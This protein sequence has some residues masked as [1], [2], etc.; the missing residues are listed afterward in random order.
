M[1]LNL[2]FFSLSISFTISFLMGCV[3]EKYSLFTDMYLS[4]SA[5]QKSLM[6]PFLANATLLP[7]RVHFTPSPPSL[8][9]F[10]APNYT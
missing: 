1:V 9:D 10:L 3:L 7:L 6:Q 4:N 8:V 5:N 2:L